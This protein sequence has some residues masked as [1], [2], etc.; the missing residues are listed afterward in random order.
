MY[1]TMLLVGECCRERVCADV[2]E[3]DIQARPET[4]TAPARLP[5]LSMCSHLVE[6]DS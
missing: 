5:D 2:G 4:H 3:T 6:L 1:E